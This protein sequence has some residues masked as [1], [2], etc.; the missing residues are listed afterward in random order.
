MVP[1]ETISSI[2][3]EVKLVGNNYLYDEIYLMGNVE[4]WDFVIL[5]GLTGFIVGCATS[6]SQKRVAGIF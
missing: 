6:P 5:Y 1:F 2:G 3:K 4:K